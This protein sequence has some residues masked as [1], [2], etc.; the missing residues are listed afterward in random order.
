M[1]QGQN[2]P[3]RGLGLEA[4]QNPQINQVIEQVLNR[5]GFKIGNA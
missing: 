3:N 5:H 2:G 1:L 4:V